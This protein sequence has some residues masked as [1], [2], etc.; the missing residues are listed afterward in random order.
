MTQSE[1]LAIGVAISISL[2][3]ARLAAGFPYAWSR[4]G[5]YWIYLGW[6]IGTSFRTRSPTR[7]RSIALR[8]GSPLLVRSRLF[9]LCTAVLLESAC[10]PTPSTGPALASLLTGLYPW[11]H[12]VLL[13]AVPIDDPDLPNLAEHMR[14]AGFASAY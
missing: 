14:A 4:E 12:G 10:T 11:N 9:V 5:R 7:W 2:V 6:L 13:N 1:Y 8:R 3:V